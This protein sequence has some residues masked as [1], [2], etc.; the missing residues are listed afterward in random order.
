MISS[1]QGFDIFCF[2]VKRNQWEMEFFLWDEEYIGGGE[3]QLEERKIRK[4]R[5]KCCAK[6]VQQE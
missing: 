3:N 1:S 6:S 2:D 4:K 5:R